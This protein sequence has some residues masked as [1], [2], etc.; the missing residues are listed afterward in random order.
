MKFIGKIMSRIISIKS[1]RGISLALAITALACKPSGYVK[2]LIMAWAFGTSPGMDAFHLASGII[3]LFV[4]GV[5]ST[6]ENAALPELVKTRGKEGGVRASETL[7]A[8]LASFTGAVTAL[9]AAAVLIAPGVIVKSFAGGFDDERIRVGARMMLWLTP[10]AVVSMLRPIL[11]AWANLTERYTL[12][13]LALTPFNLIAIP[14]LL[15]SMPFIG[16]YGVAFSMSASHVILFI[17]F[18]AALR[19]IPLKWR[20]CDVDWKV[21]GGIC[22]NS[23][24]LVILFAANT[25][26][27]VVDRYFASRLPFG[28]VAAISYA[29][30][31]VGT[32]TALANTPTKYFLS[33]MTKLSGDRERSLGTL[34]QAISISLAYFVPTG[35]FMMAAAEPVVSLVFGWGNFDARSV[36]MTSLG[37]AAYS[38][39]FAF[40]A[41]SIFIYRYA[42]AAG[43]LKTVVYLT[44][45]LIALNAFLDWALAQRWGLPGLTLATS[46]TQTVGF[47]LY[48]YAVIGAGLPRFI[49]GSGLIGQAA[50]SASLAYAAR[51]TSVF[52]PGV[53]LAACAA[54]YAAYFAAA[55]KAGLMS[56]VPENW[57]PSGLLAF[58]RAS[59]KSYMGKK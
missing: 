17:L 36:S 44:Y 46:L 18:L 48:Y 14:A 56:R 24:Y 43:K 21:V 29:A 41:A 55:Q 12:D 45:A 38:V 19:G 9:F 25:I 40:G 7:T 33:M 3:A 34:K 8:F 5:G 15:L 27:V 31:I 37:V 13:S 32:L 10:F 26:Y 2:T 47:I 42:L 23:F 39:G 59:A 1:P 52:G 58:L 30:A 54:L 49:F 6:L 11:S 28:S 20:V 22:E 51:L 57:R 53:Q 35:A 4:D 16:V 50:L